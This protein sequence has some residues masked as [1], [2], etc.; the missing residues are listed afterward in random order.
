[1]TLMFIAFAVLLTPCVVS[2]CWAAL[3]AEIAP[4]EDTQA[5]D[6]ERADVIIKA[7][8][9]SRKEKAGV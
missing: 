5:N 9:P 6:S 3:S 2:I 4:P 1:M 8:K 7:W